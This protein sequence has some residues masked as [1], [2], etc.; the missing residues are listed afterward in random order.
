MKLNQKQL[1]QRDQC[2]RLID[3]IFY[4]YG[5]I[6]IVTEHEGRILREFGIKGEGERWVVQSGPP[7]AE[8][9]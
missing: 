1:E 6:T 2:Q 9:T 4:K 3:D 5:V 7:Y 8:T